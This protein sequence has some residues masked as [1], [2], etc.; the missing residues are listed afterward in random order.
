MTGC[1]PILAA[2]IADAFSF[3]SSSP[4]PPLGSTMPSDKLISFE[5]FCDPVKPSPEQIAFEALLAKVKFNAEL[6]ALGPALGFGQFS[7]SV[8]IRYDSRQN[9]N[10]IVLAWCEKTPVQTSSSLLPKGWTGTDC[11]WTYSRMGKSPSRFSFS[12]EIHSS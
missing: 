3:S 9:A 5:H 11:N 1:Y 8:G 6:E 4:S 12:L 2:S 7:T 10:Y